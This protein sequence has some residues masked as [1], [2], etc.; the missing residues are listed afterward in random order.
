MLMSLRRAHIQSNRTCSTP[1]HLSSPVQSTRRAIILTLA[2]A[3][4]SAAATALALAKMLNF[5]SKILISYT[6]IL[7]S[8]G[9]FCLYLA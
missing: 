6:S 8:C 9:S 7:K 3:M 5:A 2:S 1:A 4:A